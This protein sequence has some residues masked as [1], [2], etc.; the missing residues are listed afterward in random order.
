MLLLWQTGDMWYSKFVSDT[1]PGQS[2][3]LNSAHISWHQ[4]AGKIKWKRYGCYRT[5]V[6]QEMFSALL[7]PLP[8][9]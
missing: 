7:Q 5:K 8:Q 3:T 2:Y 4:T 6:S 1:L 9:P